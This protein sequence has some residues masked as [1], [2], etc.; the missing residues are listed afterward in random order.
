MKTAMSEDVGIIVQYDNRIS[1]LTQDKQYSIIELSAMR[2]SRV[3]VEKEIQTLKDQTN[4]HQVEEDMFLEPE[5]LTQNE[6]YT[7][8]NLPT[9]I[10]RK[11]NEKW[12]FMT[13]N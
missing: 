7:R 10:A 12:H 1:E 9:R 11:V 4:P 2:Q 5:V 13:R 3:M 6:E 8:L